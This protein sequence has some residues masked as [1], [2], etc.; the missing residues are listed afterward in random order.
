MKRSRDQSQLA[1][2]RIICFLIVPPDS[3]FHSQTRF[4]NSSRPRSL[5]VDAFFRQLALDHHLGGDA[6][7]VGARQPQRVVAEHAMPAD[8]HVDARCA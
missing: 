1:P 2:R 6:G 5:R 4:S 7:V 8:D 3:P